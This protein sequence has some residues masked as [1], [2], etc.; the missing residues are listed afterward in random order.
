MIRLI[1]TLD[2]DIADQ[3]AGKLLG[4]G[5]EPSE[6]V[7]EDWSLLDTHDWAFW[8]AGMVLEQF[9][10]HRSLHCS[11][12]RLDSGVSEGGLPA[13]M[14]AFV[15]QLP[16]SPLRERLAPLWGMRA[17]MPQ[18]HLRRCMTR[19][20]LSNSD[21]KT[22]VTADFYRFSSL[23]GTLIGCW[24]Q[25]KPCRGYGGALSPIVGRLEKKQQLKPDDDSVIDQLLAHASITPAQKCKPLV[26][27][28][29]ITAARAL[30]KAMQQQVSVM[31]SQQQGIVDAIDSEF[32]HT[33]RIAVRRM[34]SL[35]AIAHALM[36]EGLQQQ[37]VDYFKILGQLTAPARDADVH[38][39]NFATGLGA[40]PAQELEQLRMFHQ[41]LQQQ[42]RDGYRDIRQEFA[43]ERYSVIFKLLAEWN[44]SKGDSKADRVTAYRFVQGSIQQQFDNLMRHG[45]KSDKKP[46]DQALHT[47]RKEAKQLRYTMECF[48]SLLPAKH[49]SGALQACKVL[50]SYLGSFQDLCVQQT[51]LQQFSKGLDDSEKHHACRQTITKITKGMMQQRKQMRKEYHNIFRDFSNNS[52]LK[53]LL[54]DGGKK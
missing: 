24:L 2:A 27:N 10:A 30:K 15:W 54:D 44:P 28:K 19:W 17:L 31:R 32:L 53:K 1:Y 21:G 35:L 46:S 51:C 20:S 37:L 12:S 50:Q 9:A 14:P 22:V 38:L 45:K 3:E 4:K 36:P 7:C 18:L 26:F 34:R 52:T 42:Q 40:I 23:D 8:Q 41:Y 48:V 49:T 39:L 47:L 13:A 11:I 5:F 6:M 43:Q 33:Y 25:L 29:K 16:P